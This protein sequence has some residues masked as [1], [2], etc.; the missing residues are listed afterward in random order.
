[1]ERKEIY[2]HEQVVIEKKVTCKG[3]RYK[4]RSFEKKRSL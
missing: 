3:Q 2:T 4:G 1:M